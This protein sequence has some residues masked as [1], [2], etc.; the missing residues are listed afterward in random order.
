[1]A[2]SSKIFRFSTEA[3]LCAAFVAHV[4]KRVW[5]AYPETG[6]FDLVMVHRKTAMQVGIE[7]KQSLNAEVA[8]Q[9]IAHMRSGPQNGPDFHAIL[10]P[11][12]GNAA[13]DEV[14]DLVGITTIRARSE[15]NFM[16]HLPTDWDLGDMRTHGDFFWES[17]TWHQLSPEKRIVLPDYVPDSTAGSPSPITLTQWKVR[18]IKIAIMLERR[19]VVTTADFEALKISR[20][21]WVQNGWI[22]PIRRGVYEAGR[23]PNFK[24][25]HP[26]NFDQIASDFDK[27]A[28]PAPANAADLMEACNG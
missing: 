28:T 16:P 13:L 12:G 15:K 17:L 14:L 5:Q 19:G 21:R 2:D 26:V 22:K 8:K 18:A 23:L 10:V 27:W 11:M 7:A 6:G 25:Q 24:A 4:D 20:S 1:M 3:A 9:A